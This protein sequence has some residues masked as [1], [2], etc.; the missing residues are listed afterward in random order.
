MTALEL[1]TECRVAGIDLEARGTRLKC[2]DAR[3]GLASPDSPTPLAP[4]NLR[5]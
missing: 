5:V 4:S 1:I 3:S 2:A